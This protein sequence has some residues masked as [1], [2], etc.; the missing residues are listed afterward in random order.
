MN[1]VPALLNNPMLHDILVNLNAV[2]IFTVVNSYYKI[3]ERIM[4]FIFKI[5]KADMTVA[6]MVEGASGPA[7]FIFDFFYPQ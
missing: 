5:T 3:A 2:A 4:N 6:D 7:K 1:T